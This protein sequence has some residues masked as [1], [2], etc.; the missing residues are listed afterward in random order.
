MNEIKAFNRWLLLFTVIT[1]AIM[2]VVFKFVLPE[3]FH[4]SLIAVP[5]VLAMVTMI[6]HKKLIVSSTERPQKFVNMFMAMTGIKLLLYLFIVLI[7]VMVFTEFAIPF[8]AIFFTVYILFASLEV[9][10]LLK[11]LKTLK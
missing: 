6:L 3:Q 5:I 8:I 1:Y 9:N 7:Y 2:A 10:S 4:M 11:Y